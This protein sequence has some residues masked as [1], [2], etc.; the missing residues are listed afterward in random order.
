MIG[1]LNKKI[2][3]LKS[4]AFYGLSPIG[5][6]DIQDGTIFFR[7][8]VNANVMRMLVDDDRLRVTNVTDATDFFEIG[9]NLSKPYYIKLL[10]DLLF[11]E[12]VTMPTNVDLNIS[13]ADDIDYPITIKCTLNTIANVPYNQ[14]AECV[15]I[16]RRIL[17]ANNVLQIIIPIHP[18]STDYH[19]QYRYSSSGDFREWRTL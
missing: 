5:G 18:N 1:D 15:L 8:T 11:A 13:D 2:N 4:L 3:D 10:G 12:H 19:V 6:I 17:S 16:S 9:S 14:N 7:D